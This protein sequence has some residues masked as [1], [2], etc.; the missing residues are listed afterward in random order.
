MVVFQL[1]LQIPHSTNLQNKMIKRI[2]GKAKSQNWYVTKLYTYCRLTH[3][4]NMNILQISQFF[5]IN[6]DANSINVCCML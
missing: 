1:A 4:G 3:L 6:N 5:N 2:E